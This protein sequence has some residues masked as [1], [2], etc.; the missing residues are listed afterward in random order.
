M[1]LPPLPDVF[2]NYAVRGIA[3]ILPPESVSW[4]PTTVGW[5]VLGLVLL[6]LAVRQSW[7]GWQHWLRNRYRGAAIRELDKISTESASTNAQLIA[8]SL[9]LKATALQAYPREEIAALTGRDWIEWLNATGGQATFSSES[10]SLP[11]EH[12]YRG[13]AEVKDRALASLHDTSRLWIKQHL[14]AASH[15]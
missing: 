3:E 10:S 2:G 12:V 6:V 5:R 14:Q 1:A 11:A 7:R 15:A 9:L 8:I 4:L 13:Q